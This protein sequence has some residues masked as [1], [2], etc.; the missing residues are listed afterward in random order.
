MIVENKFLC[1]VCGDEAF[2]LLSKDD[3]RLYKCSEC[4]L[5]FVSPQPTQQF[6]ADTLYSYESGYQA[7]RVEDLAKTQEPERVSFIYDYFEKVCP[8]GKILD[9]G[10]GNGQTLYWAK[11]RGFDPYGIEVNKR[12]ADHANKNGLPVYNGFLEDA[13]YD[14]NSF[15]LMFLGEIIEHINSPRDF[16][17]NCSSLLKNGGYVGITTP[18]LNCPWS[19]TN[20]LLY[21]FFGIPW[22]SVT[23]PYHLFQFND[24][25]LDRLMKEF[26]FDYVSG[27]FSWIPPLKYELGMLHLLK[28]YKKSKRITDLIFMIF[29]YVIYTINHFFFRLLHPFFKRDFQMNR[30]YKKNV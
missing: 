3:Y 4:G 29:S 30:I 8:K 10:C 5:V 16:I 2:F 6:L 13:P 28:R 24:E 23:P 26:G 27:N 25:N 1:H 11:K 19:K 18:N 15:D 22:S 21:K 7:N 9:V 20:Y 17:I 12:T 14:K